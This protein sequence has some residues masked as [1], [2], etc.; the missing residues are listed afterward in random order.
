MLLGQK[1]LLGGAPGWIDVDVD[2]GVYPY[3]FSGEVK[4]FTRLVP[5]FGPNNP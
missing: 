2:D 4:A 3:V 5:T 1:E